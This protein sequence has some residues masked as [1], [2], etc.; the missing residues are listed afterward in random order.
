MRSSCRGRK[1]C[2]PEFYGCK[3]E[4]I[5]QAIIYCDFYEIAIWLAGFVE[6]KNGDLEAR[7]CFLYKDTKYKNRWLGR[8][9]LIELAIFRGL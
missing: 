4:K 3:R 2:R 5:D 8:T 9:P 1:G 6:W 7:H